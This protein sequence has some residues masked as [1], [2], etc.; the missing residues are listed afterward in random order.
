MGPIQFFSC[1][2]GSKL[3]DRLQ[4]K[5]QSHTLAQMYKRTLKHECVGP[6]AAAWVWVCPFTFEVYCYIF[7]LFNLAGLWADNDQGKLTSLIGPVL[8][9]TKRR[10]LFFPVSTIFSFEIENIFSN[11]HTMLFPNTFFFFLP[12]EHTAFPNLSP[13]LY[14]LFSLCPSLVAPHCSTSPTPSH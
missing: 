4:G 9:T 14:L 10:P 7:L 6:T 11:K 2:N 5:I 8:N 12:N 13:L 1:N 3:Y